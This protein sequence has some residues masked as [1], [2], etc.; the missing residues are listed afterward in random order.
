[1][2][3]TDGNEAGILSAFE[4]AVQTYTYCGSENLVACKRLVLF[5]RLVQHAAGGHDFPAT[6]SVDE[7]LLELLVPLTA[8]IA[9]ADFEGIRLRLRLIDAPPFSET[10]KHWLYDAV[11]Q[12]A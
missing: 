10:A 1:M 4:S 11:S 5:C 12:V 8:A 9:K 3:L 7:D 6:E 2:K